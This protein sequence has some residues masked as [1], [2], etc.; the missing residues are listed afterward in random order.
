M[1]VWS[2]R[3]TREVIHLGDDVRVVDVWGREHRPEK[4]GNRDV[5]DVEVMPTFIRGLNPSIARWRIGVRFSDRHVP[6]VFGKAHANLIEF[7][8]EF[9]QGA[10]GTVTVH[11]PKGWQVGPE[12]L[13]FK[14]SPNST[15]QKRFAVTL[16][17]DAN[18]GAAPVRADFVVVADQKYEFS[19]YRDLLVGDGEVEMHVHSHLG[20]DGSL[21][22]E[23]RMI[24]HGE[25]PADFKCLLYAKGRRRQ[26]TQVFRL[27][28]NED[29]RTYR[30]KNGE[31]LLGTTLWL[32]IEEINGTRVLN[33]RFSAER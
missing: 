5:I 22:V 13:E 6:S 19:V 25:T 23:Q 16:P 29:L 7:R 26:R 20:V 9:S 24:N 3:P 21:I 2:D 18:S 27:G 30:L 32:R 15:T 12:N 17:L 11:G 33:H 14:L 8:N 31:E 4:D 1:V 10:G 28:S